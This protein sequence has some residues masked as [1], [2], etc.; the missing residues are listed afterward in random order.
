MI[1]Y[2]KK[3]NKY[4]KFFEQPTLFGTIDI[5]CIWGR[6]GGKFGGFKLIFCDSQ[7][8]VERVTNDVKKRRK[9][10]GYSSITLK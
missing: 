10:R 8:E 7:E 6:T 4:Y 3:E 9:Y 2:W 1:L 5:V